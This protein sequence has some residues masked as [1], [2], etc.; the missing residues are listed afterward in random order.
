MTINSPASAALYFSSFIFLMKTL[1]V[2]S[3][4]A[5]LFQTTLFEGIKAETTLVVAKCKCKAST[6]ESTF[7]LFVNRTDKNRS[8]N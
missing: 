4:L 7:P 8:A 2:V 6:E 3:S 5:M 1:C